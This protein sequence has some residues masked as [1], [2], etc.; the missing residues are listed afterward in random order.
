MSTRPTSFHVWMLVIIAIA[1][2]FFFIRGLVA[3]TDQPHSPKKEQVQ[4][5]TEEKA[6]PKEQNKQKSVATPEPKKPLK[7]TMPEVR[8]QGASNTQKPPKEA[9]QA[10]ARFH[11]LI[12][13]SKDE[14]N[15]EAV[16]AELKKVCTSN[17]FS[18]ISSRFELPK[19]KQTWKPIEVYPVSN[20]EQ[21]RLQLNTVIVVN[22]QEQWLFE[23][24]VWE[25]GQWKVEDFSN[26]LY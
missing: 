7:V 1:G 6:A 15:E 25:G 18:S 26:D 5:P 19:G 11:W 10:A 20:I 17:M 13:L 3:E 9:A 16:L 8:I 4:K 2:L 12:S 21:N 24:M 14:A 22:G 23:E